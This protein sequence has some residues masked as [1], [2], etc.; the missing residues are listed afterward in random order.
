MVGMLKVPG[1]ILVSDNVFL[2]I[3][4]YV[5]VLC[6]HNGKTAGKT[7]SFNLSCL[8]GIIREVR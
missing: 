3:I 5:I 8:C 4:F 1:S 6:K 7:C 2:E